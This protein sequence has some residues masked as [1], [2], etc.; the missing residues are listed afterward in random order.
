MRKIVSIG[1]KINND[2]KE[3]NDFINNVNKEKKK[4]MLK[5]KKMGKR[6]TSFLLM[7]IKII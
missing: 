6:L 1:K 2:K 4:L 3:I 5:Q 7:N